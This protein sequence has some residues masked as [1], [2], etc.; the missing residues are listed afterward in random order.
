MRKFLRKCLY[1]ALIV[2]VAVLVLC[3]P[4][5]A[6]AGAQTEPP[7]PVVPDLNMF[8]QW[9]VGGP[10][11]ILAVSWLLERIRW[12]QVK[13]AE[14]K[15]YIVFGCAAAVGC[16]ALAVV[17]YVPA[18]ALETIAPFFMVLSSIFVTLFVMKI[19]HLADK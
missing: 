17:K 10:G 16:L 1:V 8:L 14:E 3:A 2:V 4:V 18:L 5:A 9:L 12:F 13:S 7:A 19:F 6:S 11:S 15:Q